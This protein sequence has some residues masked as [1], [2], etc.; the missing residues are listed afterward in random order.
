MGTTRNK[1]KTAEPVKI[2]SVERANT[3][4]DYSKMGKDYKAWSVKVENALDDEAYILHT[5][6]LDSN[7]SVKPGDEVKFD[8]IDV[9]SSRGHWYYKASLKKD[10]P[11][12]NSGSYNS[13]PNPDDIKK[14]AKAIAIELSSDIIALYSQ[15]KDN[16]RFQ[17]KDKNLVNFVVDVTYKLIT[18]YNKEEDKYYFLEDKN[19]ILITS[20]VVS[21]ILYNN[22]IFKTDGLG[23]LITET[24]EFVKKI[25]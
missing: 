25:V 22:D 24:K 15:I 16:E 21:T 3:K 1:I 10:Y 9:V 14:E 18:G 5:V 23:S 11:Q 13:K 20:K 8:I 2:V 17:K 12:G 4:Q 7:C 6:G 19:M